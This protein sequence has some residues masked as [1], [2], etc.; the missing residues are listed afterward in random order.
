MFAALLQEKILQLLLKIPPSFS[1]SY[2]RDFGG[3]F[4][5]SSLF[6]GEKDELD[7][8]KDMEQSIAL[9]AFCLVLVFIKLN[10]LPKGCEG[11]VV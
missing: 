2:F 3:I 9:H 10:K 8:T 5:F 4:F 1:T 7:H 6:C 11:R